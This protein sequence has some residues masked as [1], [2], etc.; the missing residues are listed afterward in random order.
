MLIEAEKL[1]IGR[2]MKDCTG[3]SYWDQTLTEPKELAIVLTGTS[4]SV[5][6][7]IGHWIASAHICVRH[8]QGQRP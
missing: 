4:S 2:S 1:T 7:C 6:R 8:D 5:E 3:I